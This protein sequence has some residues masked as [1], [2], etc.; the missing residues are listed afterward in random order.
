MCVSWSFSLLPPS[1]CS[2]GPMAHEI[3][4]QK[5][6]FFF[7]SFLEKF[8]QILKDLYL[9]QQIEHF[10]SSFCIR[11]PAWS[12]IKI[13]AYAGYTANWAHVWHTKLLNL[14]NCNRRGR[15]WWR[16]D[17]K[18]H[19][20]HTRSIAYSHETHIQKQRLFKKKVTNDCTNCD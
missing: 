9:R 17:I 12:Y 3:W 13:E 6:L 11:N 15:N 18:T 8:E 16:S 20:F 5:K 14:W 7:H 10:F 19:K 1:Y 2:L 4:I